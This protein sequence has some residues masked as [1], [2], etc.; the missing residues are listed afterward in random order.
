MKLSYRLEHPRKLTK[1][2]VVS[3]EAPSPHHKAPIVYEG[4]PKDAK[5]LKE[6]IRYTY[7]LYGHL[8]GEFTSQLDLKAGLGNLEGYSVILLEGV[9]PVNDYQFPEDAKT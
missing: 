4:L 9:E 6:M 5:S 7:G 2:V 3:I 1:P 8:L